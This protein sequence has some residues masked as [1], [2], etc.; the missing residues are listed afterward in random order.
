M[1][2]YAR[3]ES[4]MPPVVTVQRSIDGVSNHYPPAGVMSV[5]EYVPLA[6]LPIPP[7]PA[8]QD[9]ETHDLETGQALASD[10]AATISPRA[11]RCSSISS[12]DYWW[13]VLLLPLPAFVVFLYTTDQT[14]TVR[15][16]W[17]PICGILEFSILW[18]MWANC[19]GAA[20]EMGVA[21]HVAFV[22]AIA[23]VDLCYV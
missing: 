12:G 14:S 8:Y 9:A 1:S 17:V 18:F 13:S 20:V 16:F 21:P 4:P 7:T 5:P 10:G 3:P 23:I 6:N 22:N 15:E 19:W 11:N 2:V